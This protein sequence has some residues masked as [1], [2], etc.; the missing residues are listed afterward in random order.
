MRWCCLCAGSIELQD[1][2]AGS[3]LSVSALLIRICKGAL[4]NPKTADFESV[5]D[6]WRSNGQS[7]HTA[8]SLNC[9]LSVSKINVLEQLLYVPK[10]SF[11]LQYL[12]G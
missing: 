12:A 2:I 8:Y 3:I 1:T 10:Q 4:S 6:S 9:A 7:L 11:R 5:T